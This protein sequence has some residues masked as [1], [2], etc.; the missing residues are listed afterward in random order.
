[1]LCIGIPCLSSTTSR[2]FEN[3]CVCFIRSPR[4]RHDAIIARFLL[5][6]VPLLLA[7][8]QHI[9]VFMSSSSSLLL[10]NNS[11]TSVHSIAP[12]CGLT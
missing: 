11:L 8:L 5:S 1:M 6:I 10:P 3:V 4:H 7:Y 2:S 9:Q 12:V